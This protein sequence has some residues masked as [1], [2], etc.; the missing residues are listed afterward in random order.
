MNYS[1]DVCLLMDY[2][3]EHFSYTQDPV[4][5]A[6]YYAA[7][8]AVFRCSENLMKDP[9]EVLDTLANDYEL[10]SLFDVKQKINK[11]E[12]HNAA[13]AVRELYNYLLKER[14]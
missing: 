3:K 5:S 10:K 14:K 8:E 11:E 4:T 7:K 12:Y 9:L 13:E 6:K 2:V 1:D